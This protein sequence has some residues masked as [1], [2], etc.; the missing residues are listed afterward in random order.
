M[1]FDVFI[2]NMGV[3]IKLFIEDV[4]KDLNIMVWNDIAKIQDDNLVD[5]VATFIVPVSISIKTIRILY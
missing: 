4:R 2:V 5:P 1:I 3:L